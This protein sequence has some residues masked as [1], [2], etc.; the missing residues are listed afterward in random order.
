MNRVG[1]TACLFL[2]AVFCCKALARL[3][4][5][6]KECGARYGDPIHY[7]PHDPKALVPNADERWFI[8]SPFYVKALFSNGKAV[9][10]Y[11]EHR[12]S[13]YGDEAEE[14]LLDANKSGEWRQQVQYLKGHSGF[15]YQ[16]QSWVSS[17][18]SRIAYR[19][20]GPRR[21]FALVV[22]DKAFHE[23]AK[24]TLTYYE[25][26]VAK[27]KKDEHEKVHGMKGF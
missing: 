27:Q 11:F 15:W 9:Y 5:T 3:G 2:F 22:A 13:F 23:S 26:K 20:M 4:E 16:P 17:D 10:L 6:E 18:T 14:V 24:D 7:A 25:Q 1:S 21:R 12:T 19:V 8:K